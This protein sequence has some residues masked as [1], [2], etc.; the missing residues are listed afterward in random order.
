MSKR[1]Y[2]FR[3]EKDLIAYRSDNHSSDEAWILLSDTRL[4]MTV[5]ITTQRHGEP[6]SASI[7]LAQK[8]FNK[9]VRWYMRE[10]EKVQK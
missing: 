10:Q 3:S 9:M 1:P 7:T 8:D 2:D 6:P 5:T 4:G